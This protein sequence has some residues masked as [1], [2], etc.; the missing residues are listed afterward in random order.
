[1]AKR[2]TQ[3]NDFMQA[4]GVKGGM[5]LTTGY[6]IEFDFNTGK[7][8][9]S[10]P[11]VFVDEYYGNTKLP[12]NSKNNPYGNKN[13]V[14][15]LCDEAQLP[16]VVSTTGTVTGR[17][18]GEGMINYPHTRTYTDLGL[19]FMCDAEQTPLKFLTSWYDY[20]FGEIHDEKFEY[21]GGMEQARTIYPRNTNR[22][23]R[24][25]Y[26]NDY[27]CNLRIMKTEPDNA[28]SSGRVPITYVL[29]NC[30]PYSI[31]AVPLAY[32]SSQLT[33]VTASFYYTRHTV[34][35]GV[36]DQKVKVVNGSTSTGPV[37]IEVIPF[38][39]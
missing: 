25:N 20:I 34:L 31:D 28:S 22:T 8:T 16:N 29:E 6:N 19:G 32:G 14:N 27:V 13:I 7:R 15:M 37:P 12:A 30:Y 18:L 3:I 4:I 17:Y 35:Y 36:K 10:D 2:I 33:R 9:T 38:Q 24:L 1:V 23:N 39:N 11:P 26:I 21:D 5:S